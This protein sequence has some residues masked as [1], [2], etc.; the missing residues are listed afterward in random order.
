MTKITNIKLIESDSEFL[1][2]VANK[3]TVHSEDWYYMPFW[4]RKISENT[5]KEVRFEDLP[6]S[7][8]EFI[9]PQMENND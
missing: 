2:K 6:E 3:I 7:V 8:M 5:Y 4:Y 1:E 9:N